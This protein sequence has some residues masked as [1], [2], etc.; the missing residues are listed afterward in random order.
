MEPLRILLADDHALVR[1]GIRSLLQAIDNVSVV[2]EAGDGTTTLQLIEQLQPE[3]VLMDIAMPGLN[4]L[5][6]LTQIHAQ[7]PAVRVIIL[8]MHTNEA[9]VSK[10]LRSGAVG[11][12]IKDAATI[13]LE[14]ALQAV[15]KGDT[16]LS[17]AVS[18]LLIANHLQRD[19]QPAP[20]DPLTPR[21]RQILQAIA[22]GQTTQQMARQL[23]ISVKTVE[24]HRAQLMDRLGIHDIAGLVR[25]AIKTGLITAEN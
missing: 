18:K 11:Y 14:L 6:A 1:S 13:E 9:Y 3:V 17:P 15:A 8:S 21:Q 10:A 23:N 12:L 4:G 19:S 7:F 25:Y 22:E 16:Y 2:G 20:V 5:D 24:A